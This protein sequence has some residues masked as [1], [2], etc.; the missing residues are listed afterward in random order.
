[1]AKSSYSTGR[2]FLCEQ[3]IGNIWDNHAVAVHKTI[4]QKIKKYWMSKIKLVEK[5]MANYGDSP[6][7]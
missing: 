7:L 4:N 3:E 1:M 6:N 2:E 5:I